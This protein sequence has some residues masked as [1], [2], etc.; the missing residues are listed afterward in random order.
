MLG[1]CSREWEANLEQRTELG[2]DV[3][4][5]DV[6]YTAIRDDVLGVVGSIRRARGDAELS[7]EGEAAM[8]AWEAGHSPRSGPY[9]HSAEHYGLD[10]DRIRNAF[11][12][13]LDHFAALTSAHAA[14]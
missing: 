11:A 7:S 8:L 3:A 12:P 5:L 1:W 9:R 14:R 6:D 4:V 2:A 10:S 13:Y